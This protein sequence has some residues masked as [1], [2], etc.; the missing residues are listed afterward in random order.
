MDEG[1]LN[2]AG[3]FEYFIYL[4]LFFPLFQWD[5]NNWFHVEHQLRWI[6]FLHLIFIKDIILRGAKVIHFIGR[7]MVDGNISI[8]P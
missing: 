1:G 7:V 8:T 2:T 3:D 6:Q 4:Y 5:S